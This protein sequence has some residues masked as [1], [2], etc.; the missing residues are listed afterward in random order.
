MV[1]LAL[2]LSIDSLCVGLS[3]GM[4]RIAIPFVPLL[5]VSFISS[6]STYISMYIGNGLAV[7]LNPQ[8]S[9]ILG[10]FILIGVGIYVFIS[11][12]RERRV[13]QEDAE[14]LTIRL[15]FI[16]ITVKVIEQPLKADLDNSG[17]ISTVEAVFL[18][19]ALAMDAFGASLGASM[20]GMPLIGLP[21]A[22]GI[23]NMLFIYLGV[24]IGKSVT[25][26]KDERLKYLP[27]IILILLGF[28][29]MF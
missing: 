18:G 29:T 7:F 28:L 15:N 23:F 1:I 17:S 11:A 27:G 22:V 20:G 26:A 16:E 24:Y 12:I 21:V 14:L 13:G 5:A 3:Y 2:A 10:A 6:I 19:I 25:A 4:R 9:K 8:Y